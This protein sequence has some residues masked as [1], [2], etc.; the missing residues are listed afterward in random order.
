M[1]RNENINKKKTVNAATAV[2]S[3]RSNRIYKKALIIGH[4]SCVLTQASVWNLMRSTHTHTHVFAFRLLLITRLD[5]KLIYSARI[6][7]S[8]VFWNL[9][10][11]FCLLND[12]N[13]FFNFKSLCGFARASSLS[14]NTHKQNHSPRDETRLYTNFVGPHTQIHQLSRFAIEW[15][16]NLCICFRA[17]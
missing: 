1:A 3:R 14:P 8:A 11:R 15:K 6:S 17:R 7:A 4:R 9:F 13:L 16:L 12:N 5:T 2:T 10:R